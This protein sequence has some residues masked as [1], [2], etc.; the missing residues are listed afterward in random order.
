[1]RNCKGVRG[2]FGMGRGKD[3]PVI[4]SIQ[5]PVTPRMRRSQ[6]LTVQ[7]GGGEGGIVEV[8]KRKYIVGVSHNLTSSRDQNNSLTLKCVKLS[9]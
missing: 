9:A 4:L 5:F 6:F 1:M 7:W 8:R 2:G 3:F